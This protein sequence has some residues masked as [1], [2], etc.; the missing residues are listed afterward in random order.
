MI[1]TKNDLIQNTLYNLWRTIANKLSVN[2]FKWVKETYQFNEN[3]I[4][5]YNNESDEGYSLEV[6]V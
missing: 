1:K 2:G 6:D 3:F 5:S 4:E